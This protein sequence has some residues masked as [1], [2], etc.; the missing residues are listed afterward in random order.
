MAIQYRSGTTYRNAFKYTG[1]GSTHSSQQFTA[2]ARIQGVVIPYDQTGYT[3]DDPRLLYDAGIFGTQTISSRARILVRHTETISS[4][5]RILV[6]RHTESISYRARIL[7]HHLETFSSKAR[8]NAPRLLTIRARV[9]R[10]QGWPIPEVGGPGFDLWQDTRIYSQAKILHYI[11]FPTQ[12]LRIKGRITYGKTLSM[13]AKARVVTAQMLQMRANI[14][15]KFFTTHLPA[16]FQVQQTSQRKLR[17]VFYIEGAAHNWQFTAKARIVQVYGSRVTGH[18]IVSM[19]TVFDTVLSIA[20]PITNAGTR[21][22]LSMRAK[23]VK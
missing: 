8:I 15:P 16:T 13:Q 22:V 11:A 7:I 10:R 1:A 4:R 9:S 23:V 18:F 14:L 17:M 12:L 3:Y 19:P 5:V 20:D 21:Q 2:K 6:T